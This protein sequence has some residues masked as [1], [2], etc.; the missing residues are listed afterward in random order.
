VL[1]PHVAVDAPGAG[2]LGELA[3]AGPRAVADPAAYA[4]VIEAVR[5]GYLLHYGEPRLLRGLDPDLALLAGD[6]LYALGLDRLAALG[7]LD[8]V[9]ELSDLIS[10]AA[11]LHDESRPA[12]RAAGELDALWLAAAVAVAAGRSAALDEAK[13][14]LRAG[15]PGAEPA[16]LEAAREQAAA[17]GIQHDL[18][19]ASERIE[20]APDPPPE[21]G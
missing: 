16:L 3:A 4:T 5:E 9:R 7:D 8:A 14:S 18:G 11:Q 12:G 2:P 15:S 1:A 10:L 17:S 13:R 21:L 20:S 6:H 19:L